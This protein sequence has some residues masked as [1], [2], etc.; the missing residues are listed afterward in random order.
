ME[1]KRSKSVRPAGTA[2]LRQPSIAIETIGSLPQNHQI[3]ASGCGGWVITEGK[4]V[5]WATV[6]AQQNC[7]LTKLQLFPIVP[8]PVTITKHT[9]AVFIACRTSRN[10][11][12]IWSGET[13]KIVHTWKIN[14]D[15]CE[16]V[17]ISLCLTPTAIVAVWA[18][19]VCIR[20]WQLHTLGW[21]IDDVMLTGL[22]Y[23]IYR[24]FAD[25]S[26]F[27]L[28]WLC[29]SAG[30]LSIDTTAPPA[31]ITP[32]PIHVDSM[33]SK[34]PVLHD[35]RHHS[36]IISQ[37]L[38]QYYAQSAENMITFRMSHL[39]PH[40]SAS[41]LRWAKRPPCHTSD[42]P[43][44][45]S[46]S[47]S[48]HMV[49]QT[50]AASYFFHSG[51]GSMIQLSVPVSHLHVL[52]GNGSLVWLTDGMAQTMVFD[53]KSMSWATA[54]IY[55]PIDKDTVTVQPDPLNQNSVIIGS[56]ESKIFR[57]SIHTHA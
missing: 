43:G 32:V 49:I 42:V 20:Q 56:T 17:P 4:A 44:S 21:S 38:S 10:S 24:M 2:I 31:Y 25:I 12:G 37:L 26:S 52:T 23:D 40:P 46:S 16:T 19:H 57:L 29:T 50:D 51:L 14:D 8:G 55:L 11:V 54:S 18:D 45:V 39:D 15:T 7:V 9:N 5:L 47:Y 27:S 6:D 41:A 34:W 3:I 30:L 48:R 36:F 22:H 13:G 1:R 53:D 33:S 35:D 28:V